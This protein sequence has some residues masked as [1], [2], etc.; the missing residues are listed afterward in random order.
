MLGRRQ[1]IAAGLL[2]VTL[3]PTIVMAE[4]GQSIGEIAEGTKEASAK[5]SDAFTGFFQMD[6][7]ILRNQTG[8]AEK[9]LS[10][11]LHL[12][13]VAA[14]AYEGTTP[15][16]HILQPV[17]RNDE[18]KANYEYFIAHAQHYGLKPPYTQRDVVQSNARLIR[19]F[20]DVLKSIDLTKIGRDTVGLQR[21]ANHCADLQKFLIATTTMLSG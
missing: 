2:W 14:K 21:I 9:A 1:E 10:A 13:D 19:N 4:Y 8:A 12:L 20:I 18:E 6:S 11:T 17:L 5:L 15:D 7:A 16:G 3:W